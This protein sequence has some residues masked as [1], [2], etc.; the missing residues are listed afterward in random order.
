MNGTI[1]LLM[2]LFIFSFPYALT[3]GM[4]RKK[5][6]CNRIINDIAKA[7]LKFFN[8]NHDFLHVYETDK[9]DLLD[10]MKRDGVI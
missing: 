3:K 1:L 6:D 5:A 4:Q 8:E 9:N 7:E 10:A 2:L